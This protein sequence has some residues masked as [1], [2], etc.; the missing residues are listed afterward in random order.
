MRQTIYIDVLAAVNFL[1]DYFL[2][3][4]AGLLSVSSIK[5]SRLCLG[6][7]F[8]ALCS[9]AVL[10]PP[11]PAALN[12]CFTLASCSAMSFIAFGFGGIKRFLRSCLCVLLASVCYAGAMLAVWLFIAPA[13]LA[14]NNGFVYIDISPAMLVMFTV[15]FY[16]LSGLTSRFWRRRSIVRSRCRVT[17]VSKG[18]SESFEAIIDTGNNL[19]EPFSGLPVIVAEYDA[20]SRVTPEIFA[21]KSPYSECEAMAREIGMRVIPFS[22]A[23]GSGIM[24]AFRP[25]KLIAEKAGERPRELKAY[26]GVLSGERIG[27]DYHGIVNPDALI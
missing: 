1:V 11:M 10:L 13:G 21:K 26:L 27:D 18:Q 3:Y 7:L 8:G 2:L 23:G 16:V 12:M 6:A 19:S 9:C 22:G 4:A 15:L 17:V 24:L 5:R 20:V 14:V 25:E